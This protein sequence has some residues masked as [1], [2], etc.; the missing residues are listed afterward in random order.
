MGVQ[1]QLIVLL[2]GIST[3]QDYLR[4]IPIILEASGR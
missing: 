4:V 1:W 3:F 2:K